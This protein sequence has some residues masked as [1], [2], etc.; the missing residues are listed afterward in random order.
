MLFW[1]VPDIPTA[2]RVSEFPDK[3]LGDENGQ[4]QRVGYVS[5][6]KFLRVP[7]RGGTQM[8]AAALPTL[9]MYIVATERFPHAIHERLESGIFPDAC[10]HG[11]S[12]FVCPFCLVWSVQVRFFQ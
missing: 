7:E 6:P 2:A 10:R 3:I 8:D 1:L 9:L 12:L 11:R 5:G 4:T